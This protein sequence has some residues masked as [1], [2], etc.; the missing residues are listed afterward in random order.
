VYSKSSKGNKTIVTI[1]M[2]FIQTRQD[3]RRSEKEDK[4]NIIHPGDK[5]KLHLGSISI[6][7]RLKLQW[8]GK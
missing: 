8:Q 4:T 6:K 2:S 1:N 3:R 5:F 7:L